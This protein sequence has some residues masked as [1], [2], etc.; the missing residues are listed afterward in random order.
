MIYLQK[1][2]LYKFEKELKDEGAKQKIV[3]YFTLQ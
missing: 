1:T 2:V 3:N